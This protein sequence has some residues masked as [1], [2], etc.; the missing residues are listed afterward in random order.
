MLG[1]VSMVFEKYIYFFFF[2]VFD[3]SFYE[4]FIFISLDEDQIVRI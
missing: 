3:M 1:E 2:F 4:Q